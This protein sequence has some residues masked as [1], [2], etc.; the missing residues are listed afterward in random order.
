MQD[1]HSMKTGKVRVRLVKILMLTGQP[2]LLSLQVVIYTSG[3][4][5]LTKLS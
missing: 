5:T 1:F 4:I 2:I 3:A